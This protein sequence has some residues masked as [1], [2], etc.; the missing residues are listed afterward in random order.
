MDVSLKIYVLG[1]PGM[2][3]VSNLCENPVRRAGASMHA[4][5]S[6]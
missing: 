6:T 3:F 1:M 2:T 4:E 5:V